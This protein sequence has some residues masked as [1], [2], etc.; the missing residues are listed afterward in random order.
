MDPDRRRIDRTDDSSRAISCSVDGD[1]GTTARVCSRDGRRGGDVGVGGR[2]DPWGMA[3]AGRRRKGEGRRGG[4]DTHRQTA[5]ELT[6]PRTWIKVATEGGS[7]PRQTSDGAYS[8]LGAGC[9][10]LRELTR[11]GDQTGGGLLPPLSSHRPPSPGL[12]QSSSTY[13]SSQGARG[14][15]FRVAYWHRLLDLVLERPGRCKTRRR[16]GD[17]SS[18]SQ[19]SPSS[20]SNESTRQ[21]RSVGRPVDPSK[22][23]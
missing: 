23:M 9:A 10:G 19:N 8:L 12:S 22:Q 2:G 1:E 17:E 20:H 14:E 3:T 7:V 21:P 16:A 6:Q 15:I 13:A 11:S 4:A 5:H 18:T